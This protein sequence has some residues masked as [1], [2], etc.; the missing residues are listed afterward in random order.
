[1]PQQFRRTTEIESVPLLTNFAV[2]LSVIASKTI[3]CF[4]KAVSE[5]R[6]AT[7]LFGKTV[8][9]FNNAASNDLD[10]GSGALVSDGRDCRASILVLLTRGMTKVLICSSVVLQKRSFIFEF[11]LGGSDNEVSLVA[12]DP[13]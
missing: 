1:M 2:S 10:S 3:V 5:E 6:L 12:A 13:E 8:E 7:V 4:V 9:R 11:E